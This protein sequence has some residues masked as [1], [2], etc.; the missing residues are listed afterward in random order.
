MCQLI[1][2]EDKEKEKEKEKRSMSGLRIFRLN[3]GEKS[4]GKQG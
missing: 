1:E 3:P 4:T 2:V